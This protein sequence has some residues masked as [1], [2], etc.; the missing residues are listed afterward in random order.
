MS[1]AQPRRFAPLIRRQVEQ[2]YHV[3]VDS[4]AATKYHNTDRSRHDF[5]NAAGQHESL[6]M[7]G[8]GLEILIV[9]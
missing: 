4:T 6:G 2:D 8:P 7:K 9:E 1:A 3:H 5:R